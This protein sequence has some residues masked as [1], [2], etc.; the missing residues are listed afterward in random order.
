[1]V[2][3][4][5]V[6]WQGAIVDIPNGWALCDGNNGTP[7][8]RNRF[9]VG[10]GDTYDPDDTGGAV[11]HTHTFTG[12]GHS[13]TFPIISGIQAGATFDNDTTTDPASGITDVGG[14]LP[15]YYALAFIMKL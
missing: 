6:L 7:D 5:I 12:D 11:D 9:V 2:H 3:G 13:H 1:M 14:S 10:A 4:M 8:L 15:P